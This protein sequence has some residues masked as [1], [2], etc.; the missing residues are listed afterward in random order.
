MACGD[1]LSLE[2][3]Q[4][5][6]RHQI[7]EAEVITGKV[8]GVAGGATIGTATNPVTGQ[9]QQTLPS[10]LADLGFDVQ[11]WT[12]STGGVLASANQVFLN[13]TP[14]SLGIG[15]YYAWSGTFPKTVPAGTDPALPTSG[16]IMRS[17]RLAGV[18][19]RE[20]LRRSY[21]EA[22]YNLVD[23]SFEAGGTVTSATDVLLYEAQGVAYSWTG[24]LPKTVPSGSMPD[25]TWSSVGNAVLRLDLAKENGAL[26]IDGGAVYPYKKLYTF[27]VG[28]TVV[29]NR[30]A[31]KYTDGFWYVWGG[32]FPKTI[33]ASTPDTDTTWKC[34]GL[35]SGYAVNDAQNFG[36]VSGMANAL[37]SFNAMMRSPFFKLTYP[38]KST[39]NVADKMAL[40]SFVDIDFNGSTIDWKGVILDGS[41]KANGMNVDVLHTEDYGG[42]TLGSYENIFVSNLRLLGNDVGVG[43]NFRNIR[44]YGIR[45]VY[46]EKCQR[47]GINVSNCQL[48][49]TEYFH[50]YDCC[51]RSDL[52]FTST[53]L[54]AWGDGF[55]V[56]YG[57]TNG[58]VKNGIIEV[59][60][61]TRGGRAGFVVDGYSP[62]G[63]PVTREITVD[64][65][66]VY[67]YDRPF[68]SELCGVVTVTN[69]TFE[70]SSVDKHPFIQSACVVWNANEPTTFINCKFHTDQH[71]LKT[72]GIKA[73]FI[74][75]AATKNNNA[76]SMFVSGPEETGSVEFESCDLSQAGGNWG[77]YNCNFLFDKCSLTNDDINTFMDFGADAQP[78]NLI[79]INTRL[80]G[81]HISGQFA[82]AG[83]VIKLV[84]CDVT[85]DVATGANAQLLID[86]CNLQGNVNANTV[87]RYNGQL[88]M[89][90]FSYVQNGNQQ[91]NGM[92]LGTGKPVGARPDGSGNWLV[93]DQVTNLAAVASA[94]YRWQCITA[95]SP[96]TWAVAGTLGV[97]I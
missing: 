73:K 8:G 69:S 43:I 83:S 25:G 76:V 19:A 65:I 22:G 17:S 96:G 41:N 60:D 78:H 15:D 14:G 79:L 11:S 54:E 72:A 74:R 97:G 95:G 20:A 1:V 62:P 90:A 29:S 10:I 55:L 81:S 51:P 86:N 71:F 91:Y 66:N 44:R 87:L 84:G 48:G 92:W 49:S 26:L 82:K 32:A 39:I 59:R 93:G 30:E 80:I 7:F 63:K 88:P 53:D 9:T 58:D 31:V 64:N 4:T 2:D 23:G 34:V 3:L 61:A 85:R 77:A 47:N 42:G 12:S 52:G 75:C 33:G 35:L 21:A 50:L 24:V 27:T 68:H 5:A 40:R 57:S 46:V 45:N 56:W 16:Y 38:V 36:F 70:Y 28:G 89:K 37:P 67:G 18:Q 94:P 6:K 13:D